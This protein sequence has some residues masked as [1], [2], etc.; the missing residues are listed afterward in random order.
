MTVHVSDPFIAEED[1]VNL[2]GKFVFL[3]GEGKKDLD[4]DDKVWTGKRIYWMRLREGREGAI[5]PPASFK[6]GSERGYLEYPGQPPTCWRCMEPGHLASQ[7]GA[8][9]CRRCGSRGH[10]TRACVQCYAC[11][12]MGHTFV[13]C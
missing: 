1:I 5:H 9:C 7:C 12:K 10:V 13:N 4:E 3:Q 8:E 11:G 6:I 2:L